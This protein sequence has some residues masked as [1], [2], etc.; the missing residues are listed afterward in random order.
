MDL[1]RFLRRSSRFWAASDTSTLLICEAIVGSLQ[2]NSSYMIIWPQAAQTSICMVGSMT[3]ALVLFFRQLPAFSYFQCKS[4]A[5]GQP[6]IAQ[7]A[8][9]NYTHFALLII[10][11]IIF[12]SL[13]PILSYLCLHKNQQSTIQRAWQNLFLSITYFCFT[14][15][16]AQNM[17]KMNNP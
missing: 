6:N 13:P 9:L 7:H 12:I 1:I 16:Y 10:T 11:F 17:G 15:L 4:N 5:N 8:L 2:P 14:F 3:E